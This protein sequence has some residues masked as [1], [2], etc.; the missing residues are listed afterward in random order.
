MEMAVF[1]KFLAA[2]RETGPV[3]SAHQTRERALPV[4][5]QAFEPFQKFTVEEGSALHSL[6]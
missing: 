5:G 4:N 1:E 2:A 6:P 3:V